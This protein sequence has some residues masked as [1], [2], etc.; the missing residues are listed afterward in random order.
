MAHFRS[1]TRPSSLAGG[2]QNEGS[3][4]ESTFLQ[5]CPW[6]ECK[7]QINVKEEAMCPEHIQFLKGNGRPR[8]PAAPEPR[9]ASLPTVTANLASDSKPNPKKTL[10][11]QTMRKSA[12]FGFPRSEH[13]PTLDLKYSTPP[14]LQTKP[15]GSSSSLPPTQK[16]MLS[17]I[18]SAAMSS[19]PPQF[20]QAPN[21]AYSPPMGPTSLQDTEP[22]KKRQKVS[23]VLL[24]S[25]E[26]RLNG[27]GVPTDPLSIQR[28]PEKRPEKERRTSLKQSKPSAREPQPP[29]K[30]MP[31]KHLRFTD[32]ANN[33]VSSP[34]INGGTPM[35]ATNSPTGMI[36]RQDP[37]SRSASL[38]WDQGEHIDK[39]KIDSAHPPAPTKSVLTAHHETLEIFVTAHGVTSNFYQPRADYFSLEPQSSVHKLDGSSESPPLPTT[40]TKKPTPIGVSTPPKAKRPKKLV[41]A[42]KPRPPTKATLPVTPTDLD[43]FIYSQPGASTP[44]PGL[45]IPGLNKPP[46]T[47]ASTVSSAVSQ[48]PPKQEPQKDEPLALDIDPRIHYPRPHSLAWHAMKAQEIEARGTRKQRFGKAARSLK[49]QMETQ[50]ESN[51]PWEETLPEKIQENSA[52][53]KALKNLRGMPPTPPAVDTEGGRD[54]MDLTAMAGGNTTS[55]VNGSGIGNGT[56]VN[57]GAERKVRKMKSTGSGL[58]IVSRDGI[59]SFEDHRTGQGSAGGIDGSFGANGYGMN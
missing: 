42:T 9:A 29:R 2:E 23:P 46:P 59:L 53:V 30:M 19:A 3:D 57:G 4:S 7:A 35:S 45:G 1:L 32:E 21:L 16:S 11:R 39:I 41:I 14:L 33:H 51:L 31:M 12:S 52:W 17:T 13:Q 54:P 27:I 55:S 43:Y 34:S 28:S 50:A 10:E 24:Q 25:N 36:L 22:P 6:P 58:G 20:P 38:N 47:S 49:K 44:P 15:K 48:Q 26:S 5:S 56:L 18:T 37:P 8:A 40:E